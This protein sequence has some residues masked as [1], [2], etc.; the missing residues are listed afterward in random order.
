ME[1]TKVKKVKIILD[2]IVS[3][4]Y[5]YRYCLGI[6]FLIICV[7]LELNGSSIGCWNTYMTPDDEDT[8]IIWGES[9]G[10][11]SDE[12]AVS[13]PFIFSQIITGFNWFT[14][15][16]RGG[17]TEAF[18]IYGLPIMKIVQIYRPF[19]LGFLFL[20]AAKGLS[21]FWTGRFIF[22]LLITFDFNMIVTRKNKLLSFI[23]AILV[24][25]SSQVQWWF[26][27]NGMAELF[28]FGQLALISLYY[29]I[30]TE[31]F[32]IR[33]ICLGGMSFSAGVYLLVLY[34]GY[35][36]PLFFV[37]LALAV[38]IIID[39]Y[40]NIKLKK[41]D[42]LFIIIVLICFC[43]SIA[44]IIYAARDT[45]RILLQT[46][47]PGSRIE[48]GGGAFRKYISYIQNIF[49]AFNTKNLIGDNVCE[50][51]MMF[52]LFPIGIIITI[53]NY[54]R[55]KKIDFLSICLLIPY[56]IMGFFC[57][58]GLPKI[59]AKIL[60]LSY[61]TASRALIGLGYI[62]ILLLIVS[63]SNM[64]NLEN[65]FVSV[66]ISF[67]ASFILVL[68]VKIMND[69]YLTIQM[70]LILFVI[71]ISLFYCAIR[72]KSKFEKSFF[73]VTLI[74]LMIVTGV[75]VNPLRQGIDLITNSK[76]I[77]KL[78]I[79]NNNESGT[80]AVMG[81]D[82]ELMPNYLAM[83]G[84]PT[85]NCTN[86]YPNIDL[87][88]SLD[89]E[90]KYDYVYNRYA[91]IKMNLVKSEKDYEEKFKLISDPDVIEIY[92]T[93]DELK[94]LNVK[95]IFVPKNLEEYSNENVKFEIVDIYEPYCIYKVNY[96][97]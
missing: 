11:R 53:I 80:W 5:K 18:T 86:A 97:N 34:P 27:T 24:T 33:I 51:A 25:F 52:G 17:N 89:R 96:N 58:V 77:E 28:I 56:I 85:L 90:S 6:I 94:S 72:F 63:L 57:F 66:I 69:K 44:Y 29:Y 23:G 88:K 87:W 73:S 54:I 40:K 46:A 21:L 93:V 76:L 78:Q 16:L 31:K 12:W 55:T 30:N 50:E 84:V 14:G 70:T 26:A 74:L 8:G 64:D 35:Q 45:I 68:F 95:Y 2:A 9:R 19:Q 71:C 1:I 41:V 43:L 20:G 39:N 32:L 83:A 47:Y 92:V 65:K 22:L 4:I 75:A 62:D 48:T 81:V 15:V 67:L 49:F 3:F 38:W 7:S 10:I 13:T 59:I 37:F 60:L 91:H 42:I 79:I 82:F 61:S 36:I